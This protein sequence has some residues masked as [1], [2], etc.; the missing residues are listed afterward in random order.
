MFH[1]HTG[2]LIRGEIPLQF[3][4]IESDLLAR[5]IE[6]LQNH[7]VIGYFAE[8]ILRGAEEI[9]WI[10]DLRQL[11][12]P[13]QILFYHHVWN[14]FFYIRTDCTATTQQMLVQTPHLFPGGTTLY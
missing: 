1:N 8:G 11:V 2:V 7:V 5:E 6:F 4:P 14:G 3:S 13:S 10:L 12:V 9:S